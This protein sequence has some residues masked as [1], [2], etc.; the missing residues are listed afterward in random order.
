MGA[1]FW[2]VSVAFAQPS[3]ELIQDMQAMRALTVRMYEEDLIKDFT[4]FE[5]CKDFYFY[6]DAM[7][8]HAALFFSLSLDFMDKIPLLQA[9]QPKT[10][11]DR[12]FLRV[13]K[14]TSPFNSLRSCVAIFPPILIA[15]MS[16]PPLL[17]MPPK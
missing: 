5:D 13:F 17:L 6:K 3:K 9:L 8:R 11:Q 7:E 14:S 12:E 15:L 16:R 10:P 2:V 1:L 4:G